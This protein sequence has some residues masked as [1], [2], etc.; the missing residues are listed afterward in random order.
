MA[1]NVC[2]DPARYGTETPYFATYEEADGTVRGLALWTP[3]YAVLAGPLPESAGAALAETLHGAGLRPGGVL[4]T[5]EAAE[6]YAKRWT[7][8][9]GTPL[10]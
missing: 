10:R 6:E 5:P 1:R 8:L 2:G 7:S 9:T 4:T 3:P